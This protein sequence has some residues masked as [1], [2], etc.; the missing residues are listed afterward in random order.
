MAVF[1][2]ILRARLRRRWRS[3]AALPAHRAGRVPPAVALRAE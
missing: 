2:Y 1:G 3:I